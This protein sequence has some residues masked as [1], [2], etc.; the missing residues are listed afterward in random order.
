MTIDGKFGYQ[1]VDHHGDKPDRGDIVARAI[2]PALCQGA[3]A[4]DMEVRAARAASG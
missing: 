3:V 2:L 1:E 4:G